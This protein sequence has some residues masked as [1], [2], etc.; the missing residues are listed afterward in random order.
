MK[1]ETNT[2]EPALASTPTRNHTMEVRRRFKLDEVLLFLTFVIKNLWFQLGKQRCLANMLLPAFWQTKP[3]TATSLPFPSSTICFYIRPSRLYSFWNR[4]QPHLW[5]AKSISDGLS[6]R[7]KCYYFLKVAIQSHPLHYSYKNEG[8]I[9]IMTHGKKKSPK[10]GDELCVVF[11]FPPLKLKLSLELPRSN[12][13]HLPCDFAPPSAYLQNAFGSTITGGWLSG[14]GVQLC[15]ARNKE[16]MCERYV[17][18]ATISQGELGLL[19]HPF[20]FHSTWS[21]HNAKL[22]VFCRKRPHFFSPTY[23]K[24]HFI[25]F[26]SILT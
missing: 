21:Q 10:T 13:K 2:H 17:Q 3:F 22:V 9:L 11:F 6:S 18:R 16:S 24:L 15:Q 20:Q 8:V 1:G 14:E 4:F 5:R 19:K 7:T 23:S 12:P 25:I 26:S